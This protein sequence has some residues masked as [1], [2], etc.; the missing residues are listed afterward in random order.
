MEYSLIHV[1]HLLEN[2]LDDV[3]EFPRSNFYFTTLRK[4]SNR[5]FNIRIMIFNITK[6]LIYFF[7]IFVNHI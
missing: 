6:W 2:M 4:Y 7:I 5:L 3:Q 1:C